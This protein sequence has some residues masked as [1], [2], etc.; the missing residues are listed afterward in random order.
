MG[1]PF[2]VPL[3]GRS[4]PG[5]RGDCLLKTGLV[6][7][8]AVKVLPLVARPLPTTLDLFRRAAGPVEARAVPTFYG[9]VVVILILAQLVVIPRGIAGLGARPILAVERHGAV[10]RI[11]LGALLGLPGV[12]FVQWPCP[13]PLW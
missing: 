3:A 2:V 10:T 8:S 11:C 12:V 13:L 9:R 6:G 1:L 5:A 7:L 4:R